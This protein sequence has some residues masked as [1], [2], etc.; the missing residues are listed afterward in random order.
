MTAVRWIAMASVL[1]LC[2]RAPAASA[3]PAC[4]PAAYVTGERDL[5]AAIE[6]LLRE[7]GV[8]VVDAAAVSGGACERVQAEVIRGGTR[9]MVWI[10][11]AEG[12][13]A[14]RIAEDAVAA[15]TV[16]ESWTR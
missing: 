14:Q 11:D 10:T 12:R 15:A 13:R 16:I 7:R 5:V 1:A 4:E 9:V 8:E 3:A 6:P 2:A